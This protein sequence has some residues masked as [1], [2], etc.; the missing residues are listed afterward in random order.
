MIK[1]W[2]CELKKKQ[3][4]RQSVKHLI[5]FIRAALSNPFAVANGHLN[6]ANGFVSEYFKK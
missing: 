1:R 6:V 5:G 4:S 3:C 2:N